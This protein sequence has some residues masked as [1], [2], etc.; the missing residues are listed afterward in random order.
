MILRV[1]FE[2]FPL[3]A[4]EHFGKRLAYLHREGEE[5]WVT[6]GSATSTIVL[7]SLA[8]HPLMR[9]RELLEAEGVEVRSGF[10]IGPGHSAELG[11]DPVYVA[12][13][14]YRT[15]EKQPGL[16][17]D[18]NFSEQ[19]EAGVVRRMYDELVKNEELT[20]TSYEDFLSLAKP[21]VVILSPQE[22]RTFAL[23]NREL[24]S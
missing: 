24:M 7:V 18:A 2:D 21:V 4:E 12:A 19:T 17:V 13:V 10:W 22:L 14:S 20:K 6:L 16:W 3:E 15:D 5:T 23:N 1:P 11:R 9:V 8:M